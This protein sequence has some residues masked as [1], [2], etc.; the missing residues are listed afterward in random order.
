MTKTGKII[1]DVPKF[2][3]LAT[4]FWIIYIIAIILAIRG[5]VI[6]TIGLQDSP[7]NGIRLLL[8]FI[9]PPI[10]LLMSLITTWLITKKKYSTSPNN[11]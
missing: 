4:I 2:I 5:V 6:L 7:N 1:K 9:L 11:E 8:L 3:A 10:A